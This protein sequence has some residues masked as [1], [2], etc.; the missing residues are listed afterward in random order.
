MA[1]N[2]TWTLLASFILQVFLLVLEKAAGKRYA[3]NI[4]LYHIG[5][6]LSPVVFVDQGACTVL[7][8]FMIV[9]DS[10]DSVHSL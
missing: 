1:I 7:K 5:F 3:N 9:Y 2:G 6:L 8:I 4:K 10:I